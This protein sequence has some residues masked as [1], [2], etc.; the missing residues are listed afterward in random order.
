MTKYNSNSKP[1]TKFKVE[2]AKDLGISIETLIIT[3]PAKSHDHAY[4]IAVE[5]YPEYR[6]LSTEKVNPKV[7]LPT[8]VY[9][10]ARNPLSEQ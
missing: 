2:I 5:A 6:I 4:N 7:N 10:Y 8:R 9:S 1:E 3:L